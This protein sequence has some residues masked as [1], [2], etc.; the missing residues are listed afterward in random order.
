MPVI[1]IEFDNSKVQ[2]K[3]ILLL[4]KSMQKIVSGLGFEDV[5]VYANNSKIKVKVHPIEIFVQ[6]SAHKVPNPDKTMKALSSAL[7]AW[8]KK[9]SFKSPINLSLIPMKWRIEKG[10]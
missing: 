10:I 5:P 7:S 8:K 4:S 3:E 1:Y 9:S 6:V 2:E